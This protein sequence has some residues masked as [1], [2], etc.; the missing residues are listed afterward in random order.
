MD[1]ADSSVS[2]RAIPVAPITSTAASATVEKRRAAAI[3]VGSSPVA[4]GTT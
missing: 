4:R 1:G 3:R 2:D